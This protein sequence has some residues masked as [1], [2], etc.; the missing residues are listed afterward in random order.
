MEDF[1]DNKD[2][3]STITYLKNVYIE[4]IP[5]EALQDPDLP[6][7]YRYQLGFIAYVVM[8]FLFL[9]S[10]VTNFQTALKERYMSFQSDSGNCET[11][12]KPLTGTFK[13]DYYGNWEGSVLFQPNQALY[14]IEFNR[15]SVDDETF[16]SIMQ[17][18]NTRIIQPFVEYA[19]WLPLYYILLY[20]MGN[21]KSID[22]NGNKH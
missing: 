9:Y 18:I 15:L 21:E 22:V 16:R 3:D 14:E 8:G 13:M 11:V 12:S 2:K 20:H 1:K 19:N 5:M 7:K 17:D 6:K 10:L 4:N